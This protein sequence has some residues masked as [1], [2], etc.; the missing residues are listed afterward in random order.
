VQ[1]IQQ[2]LASERARLEEER[3]ADKERIRRGGS[4]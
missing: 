4:A 2:Q 1:K 3:E